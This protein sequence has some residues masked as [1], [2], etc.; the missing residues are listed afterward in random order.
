MTEDRGKTGHGASPALASFTRSAQ[1]ASAVSL[2]IDGHLPG[3]STLA[4][5]GEAILPSPPVPVEV[6]P[7]QAPG[8]LTRARTGWRFSL[9][10]DT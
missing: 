8:D 10:R 5:T 4:S 1:M 3:G 9:Q 2:A 7:K 6:T